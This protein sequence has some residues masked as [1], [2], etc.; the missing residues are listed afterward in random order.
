VVH[1]SFFEGHYIAYIGIHIWVTITKNLTDDT[2]QLK[3]DYLLLK[4]RAHHHSRRRYPSLRRLCHSP[5]QGWLFLEDVTVKEEGTKDWPQSLDPSRYTFSTSSGFSFSL[6]NNTSR[7]SSLCCSIAAKKWKITKK[8]KRKYSL[9]SKTAQ[10]IL[11]LISVPP[12]TG[13]IL[14]GLRGIVF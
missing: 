4:S 7:V 2:L 8:K 5:T 12:D 13:R 10:A 1:Y 3:E 14:S 6:A 9:L 11:S